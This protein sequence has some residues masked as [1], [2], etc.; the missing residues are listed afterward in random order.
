M[1][2]RIHFRTDNDRGIHLYDPSIVNDTIHFS[3]CQYVMITFDEMDG[4]YIKIPY[5]SLPN[6]VRGYTTISKRFGFEIQA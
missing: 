6:V 2:L 3:G 1:K 4:R 5:K